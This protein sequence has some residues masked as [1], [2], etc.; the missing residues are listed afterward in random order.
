[1]ADALWCEE[2]SQ[3]ALPTVTLTTS[4][5]LVCWFVH[6]CSHVAE[7][8][9]LKQLMEMHQIHIWIFCELLKVCF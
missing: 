2:R 8:I 1:M 5:H 6:F 9:C 4:L 3:L 7:F